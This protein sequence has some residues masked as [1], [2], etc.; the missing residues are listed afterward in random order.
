MSNNQEVQ[1]EDLSTEKKYFSQ[2]PNIIHKMGLGCYIVAYYCL[3]KSIAGDK[4]TCFMSQKNLSNLLGCSDRQIRLMNDFMSKPFQILGGK[5]LIKI[6][7]RK[8]ENGEI[9]PNLVQIIDI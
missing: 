8:D 9:L 5:P 2:I 3:L 7:Q 6:T 1:V 4:N